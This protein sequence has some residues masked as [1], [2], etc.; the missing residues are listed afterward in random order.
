MQTVTPNPDVVITG[1]VDVVVMA[2]AAAFPA[3]SM[4]NKIREVL[5]TVTTT[6]QYII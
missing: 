5:P 1:G 6:L 2:A 3:C 4:V